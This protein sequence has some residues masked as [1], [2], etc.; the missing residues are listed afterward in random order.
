REVRMS[1]FTVD[2]T[3]CRRD[4]YCAAVCPRALIIQTGDDFPLPVDEGAELCIRC[5]HCVAVC[6]HEA[7]VLK[8]FGPEAC[9]HVEP[10]KK[11][12][13]D[14]AEHFLRCRRSIRVYKDRTVE[15][16]VLTRLIETA[17]YAPSGHNLQ[18]VRWL[19]IESP[20]EV[21]RLAGMVIDWMRTLTVT[22]PDIAAYWRFD[23]IIAAWE[24]GK[25]M[26]LRGAP[27]LICAHAP[28]ELLPARNAAVIALTYMELAATSMGLGTCW[29]GYFT[30]A[31]VAY[32]PLPAALGLPGGHECFGAVMVGYP[33][34]RYSRMP[35]RNYPEITWR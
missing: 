6:P 1:Y 18:P 19:V 3:K 14:Q 24:L 21:N 4:G 15:R 28:A 32:P 31:S 26:V 16:E 17:R 8:S 35:P 33:K 11:L 22:Q 25:D 2:E 23:R 27:H 20:A 30:A 29:A 12:T 10:E 7:M 13:A 9:R 34:L 5:G